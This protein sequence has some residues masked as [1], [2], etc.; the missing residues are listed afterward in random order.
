[1]KKSSLIIVAVIASLFIGGVLINSAFADRFAIFAQDNFGYEHYTSAARPVINAVYDTFR[2]YD[3]W[4]RTLIANTAPRDWFMDGSK[5]SGGNDHLLVEK[6]DVV[7][8]IG[9]GGH[10][11]NEEYG[12]EVFG[13]VM[14]DDSKLFPLTQMYLGDVS[15]NNIEFLIL[16]VCQSMTQDL[17]VWRNTWRDYAGTGEGSV[18]GGIHQILGHHGNAHGGS[19]NANDYE[20]F[21]MD[22]YANDGVGNSWLDDI[23]Q[24]HWNGTDDNCPVAYAGRNTLANATAML[25]NETFSNRESYT[26]I[27]NPPFFQ[28]RFHDGCDP[29]D[30][31]PM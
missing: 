8:W 12:I 14:S 17:D 3:W 2:D 4:E 6:Y 9:H 26:D 30:A 29:V 27:A 13:F 16:T 5:V 15:G 24:E 31:D 19:S 10:V 18:F 22:G 20:T 23:Y 1:M 28:R 25:N 11:E 21:I 7:Y